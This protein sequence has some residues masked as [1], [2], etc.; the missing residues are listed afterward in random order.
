VEVSSQC[1]APVQAWGSELVNYSYAPSLSLPG[2]EAGQDPDAPAGETPPAMRTGGESARTATMALLRPF[3]CSWMRQLMGWY[4]LSRRRTHLPQ[5]GRLHQR[6]RKCCNQIYLL[7]AA[8]Y[9]LT[10]LSTAP[11]ASGTW[12]QMDDRKTSYGYCGYC[13]GS[14]NRT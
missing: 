3:R 13:V 4:L 1:K 6:Q 8:L 2:E 9:E 14:M 12:G 7:K 10:F 11:E 5:F